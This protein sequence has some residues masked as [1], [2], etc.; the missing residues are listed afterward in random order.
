MKVPANLKWINFGRH[1]HSFGCKIG[2]LVVTCGIISNDRAQ[3]VVLEFTTHYCLNIYNINAPI[4]P[5]LQPTFWALLA[6]DEPPDA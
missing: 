5:S 6:C 4:F 2:Y 1:R 3:F